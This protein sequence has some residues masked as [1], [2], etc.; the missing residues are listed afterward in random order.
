[1]KFIAIIPARM[2]STRF[3]GKPLCRLCGVT[4]IEHVFRRTAMC[5]MLQDV[6]VATCDKEIAEEVGRF[7]GKFIMTSS[8]HK[9]CSD[10]VAEACRNIGTDADVVVNVQGDEPL[11]R[12]EMIEMAVRPFITDKNLVCSNLIAGIE[13]DEEFINPNTIKVVKDSRDYALYFSR[14]P[15]PSNKKHAGDYGRYKQV[16]VIPFRREFLLKFVAMKSTPIESVE[17][18]DMLRILEN[19]DKV[20]LVYC[21]YRS[22]SVDDELDRKKAEK[23]MEKDNLFA[24]YG[25]GRR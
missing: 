19:G 7:G 11:V 17:S 3:P 13:S 12:P 20:K 24:L 8:A 18:I 23:L 21:D 15:I 9:T 22:A 5:K 10:R 2:A 4:M 25:K 6:Y 1:M 14:E 16:C